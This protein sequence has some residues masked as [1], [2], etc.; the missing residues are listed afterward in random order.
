M[1][2]FIINKINQDILSTKTVLCFNICENNLTK[3]VQI[4]LVQT[5]KVLYKAYQS[6]R[7]FEIT[8]TSSVF[9]IDTEFYFCNSK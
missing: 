5:G 6:Q 4:I 7:G 3:Q 9:Q 2:S 8:F 1:S